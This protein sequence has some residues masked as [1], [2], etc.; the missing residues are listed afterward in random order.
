MQYFRHAAFDFVCIV[1]VFMWCFIAVLFYRDVTVDLH[2][3]TDVVTLGLHQV[4]D[5]ITLG[6]HHITDIVTLRLHQ[7][8]DTVTLGLHQITDIQHNAGSASDY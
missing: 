3:I 5:M 7:I 2:H 6:L 1:A 4:I 8:T